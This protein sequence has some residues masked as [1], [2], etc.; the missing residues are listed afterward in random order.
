ML[1]RETLSSHWFR[2]QVELFPW[3]DDAVCPLTERHRQLVTVLELVRVERFVH[4]WRGLPGRMSMAQR[5]DAALGT[6]G[7]S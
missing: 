4:G 7:S 3:L 2:I 6:I 1:L 5:S